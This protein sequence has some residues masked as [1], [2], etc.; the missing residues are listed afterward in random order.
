M[1]FFIKSQTHK[2][3]YDHPENFL[4]GIFRSI[5]FTF[6]FLFISILTAYANEWH[7]K[8]DEDSHGPRCILFSQSDQNNIEMHT[9][10]LRIVYFTII[11]LNPLITEFSYKFPSSITS[12]INFYIKFRGTPF[13]LKHKGSYAWLENRFFEQKLLGI[14]LKESFMTIKYELNGRLNEDTYNLQ[15]LANKLNEL[16]QLCQIKV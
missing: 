6:L 1:Y 2:S 10:D 3:D 4:V 12:P 5:F 15:G 16:R 11:S 13:K 8:I 7:I 14:A 9:K